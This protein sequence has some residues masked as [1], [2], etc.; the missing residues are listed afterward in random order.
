MVKT[1]SALSGSAIPSDEEIPQ[2]VDYDADSHLL[3]IRGA[4]KAAVRYQ[5]F[6]KIQVLI[7]VEEGNERQSIRKLVMTIL[8]D[9]AASAASAVA[10]VL[11]A[12]AAPA[13]AAQLKSLPALQELEPDSEDNERVEEKPPSEGKKRKNKAS[14]PTKGPGKRQRKGAA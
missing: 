2:L 11:A 7:R 10:A 3:T 6:Q 9:D 5:V 8:P 14:K 4:A 1:L 13:S 12:T